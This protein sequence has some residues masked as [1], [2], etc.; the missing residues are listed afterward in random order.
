MD[1]SLMISPRLKSV[2]LSELDLDDFEITSTMT[3][4]S[5]PG[6]DSLSHVRII[7]AIEAAYG[8]RFSTLEV[9][10]MKRV[11]D[12]QELVDRKSG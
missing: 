11:G 1:L 5:V 12:L 4:D 8:I 3:A 7:L 10:K 6:W 2:I 9:L